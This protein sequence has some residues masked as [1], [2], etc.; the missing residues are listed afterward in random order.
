MGGR[1]FDSFSQTLLSQ[2]H[3]F[4]DSKAS[5]ALWSSRPSSICVTTDEHNASSIFLKFKEHYNSSD[6]GHRSKETTIPDRYRLSNFLAWTSLLNHN[7]IESKTFDFASSPKCL[8]QQD[9]RETEFLLKHVW[10]LCVFDG[11]VS[12]S[13]FLYLKTKKHNYFTRTNKP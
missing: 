8:H 4:F 13:H 6:H 2:K 12:L 3:F 1:G 11:L 5:S 9:C 10:S 7:Q